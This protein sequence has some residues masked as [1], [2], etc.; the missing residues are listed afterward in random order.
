[1]I[2]NLGI[3]LYGIFLKMAALFHPKAKKWVEGRKGYWN[4]LPDVT[5][6]KVVWFHCASLG[7]YDQGK[8]IMEAWR[9]KFPNDYILVTFFS[10][11]GFDQIKNKSVG[12]YT[13]YLPL[14]TVR[15]ARKFV[16]HFH[17]KV[18]FFV[19]YEIWI[20]H[21]KETKKRGSKIY[22]ISA[23]FRENHRFF[24]WYGANFR[25][26]LTLFDRIFVQNEKSKQL[27]STIQLSQVTVA[28]DTRFDRVVQRTKDIKPNNILDPWANGENIF[29]IGSSWPADEAIIIPNINHSNIKEKVI[30]APHE[31]DKKHIDEIVQQLTVNH[32]LYTKLQEGEELN[33][34]TQVVILD[35]IGVLADAY[36]YGKIAYVGG[37]FGTGL[38]NILEPAAFG[39]PVI[40]GVKH[41]KFPEAQDFINHNIGREINDS[42]QFLL[43]YTD[44]MQEKEVTE[45]VNQFVQ[46]NLGATAIIM[47]QIT[48]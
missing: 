36:Q 2:Y 22:S 47:R 28:G 12:D 14:D 40:F 27:L 9:S 18:T 16:L 3:F 37:G 32:Q 35:C 13:C 39:L 29:V 21:L 41:Q 23:S 24:K 1:M 10:P 19:K 7:E 5:G 15:N 34:A 42:Q 17:P 4:H 38:H 11:S 8:P 25:K 20:N 26:A 33:T 48:E 30:L 46:K 6:K 44:F 31:V 45:R 43:A